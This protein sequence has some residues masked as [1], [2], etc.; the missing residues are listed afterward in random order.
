MNQTVSA[1]SNWQLDTGI[2]VAA[3]YDMPL[4]DGAR[5]SMVG[6]AIW[7]HSFGSTGTSQT[8]SL[9][10]GGSPSTVSGLDTGRDRLRVV[11]GVEYHANPNL[12]VSL[13]YTATLGGLEISHA[14]R[15]ALRVRF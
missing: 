3:R 1:A 4:D 15:L 6:N 11:A 5:L 9:E 12:I 2:S 7:Q 8:V 10:G 14:A 13:D